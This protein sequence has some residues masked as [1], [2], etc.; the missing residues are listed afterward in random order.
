MKNIT[1]PLPLNLIAANEH[2]YNPYTTYQWPRQ[3][4]KVLHNVFVTFSGFCL[5]EKGLVP[6]CHHDYPQQHDY[7]LNEASKYYYDVQ[8]N[9]ENLLML[10]DDNVYLSIFHPWF[11][12]YHWICESIFR[13]W[14]VRDKL[15]GMVLLL[16]EY[17]Q[18]ADFIVASLEPFGIKNVRYIPQG[19]SVMVRNLCLPQIKPICD[20]YNITHLRDVRAFYTDYVFDKKPQDVSPMD[21]IYIS[22][23]MAPRRQIVNEDDILPIAERNGFTIFH[24]E[25]FNFL[26][27]VALFARA[28]YVIGTHGSGLTNMLFM[29]GGSSVLELHKDK[30]NELN[31]PSPLFWYLANGLK[32][33][34]FHQLCETPGKE[35]YF[36]SDYWIDPALFQQNVRFMLKYSSVNNPLPVG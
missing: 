25:Q 30:T 22:R 14:L 26:Q 11:N 29:P 32:I 5:N 10:D 34:Y 31:H 12:Y 33:N 7:Y 21:K 15:D 28:K 35:D 27:Q 8:D 3:R 1:A 19:N 2:H 9:P 20:A 16:P 18:H 13:L 6:E 4:V 17:Y 36:D 24:P 23:K